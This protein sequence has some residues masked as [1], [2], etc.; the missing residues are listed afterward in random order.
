MS[1][2]RVDSAKPYF[3]TSSLVIGYALCSSLLAVINTFA[4]TKFKYPGLLTALQ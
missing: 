3:A 4:I 1:A 2:I